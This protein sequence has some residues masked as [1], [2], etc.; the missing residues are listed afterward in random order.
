MMSVELAN[1]VTIL[2]SVHPSK[3]TQAAL[4]NQF[5]QDASTW[6]SRIRNAIYK[7][8]LTEQGTFAYETNGLGSRYMMDDA[9]VPSL[10]SLPYLGFLGV[11]SLASFSPS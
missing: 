5:I 7:Y 8:A 10:L 9:N 2:K 11:F 1:L 4:V 6:T 3:A